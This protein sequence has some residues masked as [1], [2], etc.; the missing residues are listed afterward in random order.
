M[1][2]LGNAFTTGCGNMLK[3]LNLWKNGDANIANALT[4]GGM[5]LRSVVQD[6]EGMLSMRLGN[7]GA[8]TDLANSVSQL[9]VL[10]AKSLPGVFLRN[11]QYIR[12][13]A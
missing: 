7:L 4:E 8:T 11:V 5:T 1:A 3:I 2:S 9:R 10:D 13:A 6:C 12:L